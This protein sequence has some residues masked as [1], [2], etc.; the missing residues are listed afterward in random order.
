MYSIC[1]W[2]GQGGPDILHET[3]HST[4]QLLHK[5]SNNLLEA[6][7]KGDMIPIQNP[8]VKDYFKNDEDVVTVLYLSDI[9]RI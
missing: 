4:S 1:C 8:P 7:E 9:A 5:Q 2:G 6:Q 3:F